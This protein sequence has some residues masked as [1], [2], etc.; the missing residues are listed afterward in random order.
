MV[1]EAREVLAWY[2][3]AV[4]LLVATPFLPPERSPAE[5]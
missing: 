2:W 4:P 5:E 1:V 3:A